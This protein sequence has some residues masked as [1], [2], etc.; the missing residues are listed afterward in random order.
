MKRQY[1]E[2]ILDSRLQ[3]FQE[4]L[5][6]VDVLPYLS[7]LQKVDKEVIE[8]KQKNEGPTRANSVLVDRIKRRHEGFQDFVQAL[9][10]CGFEH[11]ALLLDPYYH[12]PGE[13]FLSIFYDYGFKIFGRAIKI[14]S[15]SKSF[16]PEHY[17][18][19]EKTYKTLKHNFEQIGA[20]L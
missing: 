6:P 7:C 1:E 17:I 15:E 11:T 18:H 9:R 13:P 4:E 10:K 16:R 2:K 20:V 12:Y 19:S 5:I 14:E 8:A 3:D